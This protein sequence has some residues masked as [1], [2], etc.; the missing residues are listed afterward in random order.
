[1]AKN[2]YK[3]KYDEVARHTTART[4]RKSNFG[5][6][7]SVTYTTQ[8][9]EQYEFFTE[10]KLREE[11]ATEHMVISTTQSLM[12]TSITFSSIFRLFV[13][14]VKNKNNFPTSVVLGG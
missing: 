10:E 2:I 5:L 9:T 6:R 7:S 14:V 13:S 12:G 1:M 3:Q 8:Q 11:E 4:E